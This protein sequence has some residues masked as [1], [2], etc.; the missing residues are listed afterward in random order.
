M[1]TKAESLAKMKEKG[2]SDALELRTNAAAGVLTE[3]EIIDN[4]IAAPAFDPKKD[5]SEWPVNSP[6]KDENQVWLLLQ[7]H[8][9]SHYEGRPSTLRALWGLAHTKNPANAKPYVAP[10][11]TSG[12]YNTDEC[13][14]W[15]DGKVY[16]SVMDNNAYDPAAYPAG[17]KEVTA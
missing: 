3:T 2:A 13:V 17:W 11:G 6:V 7:P 8:N 10:M 5:Y 16:A 4:E 14:L 15:T 9:A 1:M 12:L